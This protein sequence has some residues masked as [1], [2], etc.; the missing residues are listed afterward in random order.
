[1]WSDDKYLIDYNLK[2]KKSNDMLLKYMDQINN[3]L[4]IKGLK[5]YFCLKDNIEIV[6]YKLK[7]YEWWEHSIFL[8]NF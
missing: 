1:M 2:I 4:E 3:K 7:F 5:W 8:I 6:G